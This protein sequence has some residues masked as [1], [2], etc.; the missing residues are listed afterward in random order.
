[1]G[2]LRYVWGPAAILAQVRG[3]KAGQQARG[4]S[5]LKSLGGIAL[6]SAL[7]LGLMKLDGALGMN[8]MLG[9][10]PQ[11]ITARADQP[12]MAGGHR[13]GLLDR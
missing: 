13:T 10:D 2:W 7:Y 1:M 5:P 6:M 8:Q 12:L 4:N 11:M 3:Y 9:A